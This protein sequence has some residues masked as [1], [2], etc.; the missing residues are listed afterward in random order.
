ME[1]KKKIK[2][3]KIKKKNTIFAKIC[4]II[5]FVWQTQTIKQQRK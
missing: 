1:I 2:I 4:F 5:G 3:K